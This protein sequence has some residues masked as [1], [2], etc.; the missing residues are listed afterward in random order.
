MNDESI[1]NVW[2]KGDYHRFATELIW[3]VGPVVVDAAGIGPGMRV[4]DVAA[5]SGNVALR[6]AQRGATV[7]ASDITPEN[8]EAGKRHARELGVSLEWVEADA[9]GLPFAD[10]SFDA[11]TSAFGALFAPDHRRVADEMIRVCKPGGTIAMANFTPQGLFGDFVAVFAPYMPP[12]EPG[13]PAPTSW[14]DESYVRELF[15]DRV[16]AL[17]LVRKRYIERAAHPQAYCDLFKRTFG[18]TIA[19]YEALAAQPERAAALDR[20]FLDF[21]ERS[22]RGPAGG[23]AEYEYEYLLVVARVR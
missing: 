13:A 14:G 19:V 17:E 4:L 22:N 20:D 12:A 10:R 2:S 16:G 3:E 7:V 18:P 9:Q 5:G 8:F 15:G 1:K 21:A 6:A 23:P 11:V